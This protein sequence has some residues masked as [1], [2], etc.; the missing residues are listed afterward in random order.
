[1]FIPFDQNAAEAASEN[2]TVAELY[3]DSVQVTN[4]TDK[5]VLGICIVSVLTVGLVFG[6]N[7]IVNNM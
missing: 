3:D 5:F 2:I 1:M 7:K 6:I 4:D